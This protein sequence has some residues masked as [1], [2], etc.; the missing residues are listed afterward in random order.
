MKS[1]IILLCLVLFVSA[2]SS[3]PTTYESSEDLDVDRVE[4]DVQ[5]LEI[6]VPDGEPQKIAETDID[7]TDSGIP[8]FEDIVIEP[9]VCPD[10]S[11]CVTL[12]DISIGHGEAVASIQ[13]NPNLN[14]PIAILGKHLGS[15]I[16]C[17]DAGETLKLC[18]EQSDVSSRCKSDFSRRLEETSGNEAV[19]FSGAFLEPDSAC[20]TEEVTP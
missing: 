2:C 6:E 10:P 12:G 5:N 19:A 17:A 4:V 8:D 15:I 13:Y 9:S 7:E 18:V 16:D 20:I 11:D 14:D 3:E 1:K